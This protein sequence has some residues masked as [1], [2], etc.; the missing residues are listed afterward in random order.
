VVTGNV[1]AMT[2]SVKML[3]KSSLSQDCSA[4]L[5]VFGLLSKGTEEYLVFQRR[6]SV[7]SK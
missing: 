2:G 6:N 3:G 7:E 1:Q 4:P 5:R